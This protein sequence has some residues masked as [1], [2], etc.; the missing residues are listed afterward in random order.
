MALKWEKNDAIKKQFSKFASEYME[1]A[2]KIKLMLNEPIEPKPKK[3]VAASEGDK[4]KNKMKEAVESAIVQDKPNIKWDDIAGLEQVAPR[5]S[6]LAPRPSPLPLQGMCAG[7]RYVR[8]EGLV[9]LQGLAGAVAEAW[10]VVC[11]CGARGLVRRGRASRQRRRSRRPSSYP[12]TSP[13]SSRGQ[14]VRHG[15]A[16]CSTGRPARARATWPK[17]LPP[18]YIYILFIGIKAVATEVPPLPRCSPLPTLPPC[19]SCPHPALRDRATQAAGTTGACH[20]PRGRPCLACTGRRDGGAEWSV[21]CG[22][23]PH[24]P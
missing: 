5:P 19:K 4:D 21:R 2:E 16:S 14:V 18:R 8:A 13:S 17:P 7:R 1:R 23:S 6:P 22:A 20:V 3:A 11:A 24:A 12:S 9:H 15:E 10:Q